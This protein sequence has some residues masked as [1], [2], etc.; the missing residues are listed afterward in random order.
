MNLQ[1]KDHKVHLEE[2]EIEKAKAIKRLEDELDVSQQKHSIK[3]KQLQN[4]QN[5]IKIQ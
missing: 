5:E 3:Y 2:A 1:D 4:Q